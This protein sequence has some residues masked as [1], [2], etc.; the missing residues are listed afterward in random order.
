M[1]TFGRF[2]NSPR[3]SEFHNAIKH[4][5]LTPNLNLPIS[6]IPFS[7]CF[8]CG[9]KSIHQRHYPHLTCSQMFFRR[10]HNHSLIIFGLSKNVKMYFSK[11][12]QVS[13][14]CEVKTNVTQFC[15]CCD[16]IMFRLNVA[17]TSQ[18]SKI[19]PITFH[20]K[21][22]KPTYTALHKGI[23]VYVQAMC[24]LQHNTH[25]CKGKSP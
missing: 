18:A 9:Y 19:I 6:H 25:A 11:I 5:T 15:L 4:F 10:L 14:V 23:A 16:A 22:T 17:V 2:G 7:C 3:A 24:V 13:K 8:F 1:F 12:G 20:S 21:S